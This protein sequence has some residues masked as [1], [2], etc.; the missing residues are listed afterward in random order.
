[1]K[2]ETRY[3]PGTRE[4]VD[5]EPFLKALVGFTTMLKSDDF[6]KELEKLEANQQV[7]LNRLLTFMTAYSLRFG[8]AETPDARAAYQQLFPVLAERRREIIA[9]IAQHTPPEGAPTPTATAPA[10]SV[11]RTLD[12]DQL[13]K[14]TKTPKPPKPFVPPSD[15]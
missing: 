3:P 10:T 7:S 4:Y 5:S 2:F 14:T 15:K 12:F 9:L 1:D 13:D 6:K 11:F 8:N